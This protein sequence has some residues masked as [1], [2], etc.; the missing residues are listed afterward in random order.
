MAERVW[1]L[2]SQ[3]VDHLA[4]QA[5]EL[6]RRLAAFPDDGLQ[7][8]RDT[9]LNSLEQLAVLVLKEVSAARIGKTRPLG[10]TSGMWRAMR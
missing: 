7:S 3:T 10:E 2:L 1:K 4:K 9:A 5:A 6:A 8:D